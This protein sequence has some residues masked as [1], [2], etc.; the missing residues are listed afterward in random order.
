MK[1]AAVY[2]D[3]VGFLHVKMAA[4]RIKTDVTRKRHGE[5]NA[6]VPVKR[7]IYK[8]SVQIVTIDLH[9]KKTKNIVV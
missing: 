5:L 7:G 8:I 4:T 1:L 3:P 9:G 6:P 2:K